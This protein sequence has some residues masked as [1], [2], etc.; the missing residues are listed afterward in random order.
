MSMISDKQEINLK[1]AKD[2]AFMAF[3]R[4]V[5][6]QNFAIF[7]ILKKQLQKKFFQQKIDE[8]TSHTHLNLF[9]NTGGGGPGDN[10]MFLMMMFAIFAMMMFM[11]RPKSKNERNEKQPPGG[12]GFGG[13]NNQP[14]PDIST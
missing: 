5:K 11:M 1:I 3:K 13:G 10:P 14:P 12:S 9:Q 6:I 8:V 4:Q 7:K 2:E